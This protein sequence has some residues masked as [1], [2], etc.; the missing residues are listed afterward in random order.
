MQTISRLQLL[1]AVLTLG[2]LAGP[3]MIQ[4][5][6]SRERMTGTVVLSDTTDKHLVDMKNGAQPVDPYS[7]L[8]L[9]A[10]SA[11]VWDVSARQKLFALNS[12]ARLP[13]ASVTKIMTALVAA[14]LL[15]PETKITISA[16]DIRGEGDTG[17]NVGEV[18]QFEKL[19]QFTLVASSNDGASAI[20][21]TAGARLNLATSTSAALNK[22][23][24]V[25]KM[26][27]QA[28][29]MGLTETSFSN[30]TG[31]DLG[32]TESG[33]YGSAR[34]MAMLFDYVFRKY[35]A[36][37]TPTASS[38]LDVRSESDILHHVVNTNQDVEGI[39]GIIGSKTGYTDL[40]GGN[41]VVVVDIGI[42][43]PIV[44]AVLGSTRE[45]RFTDV[46]QLIRAT[47]RSIT[48]E[49]T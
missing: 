24:F 30:E 34:D 14:E 47:T 21:A 39:A 28:Q 46:K 9:R 35:P 2:F 33:A 44:I 38:V 32:S 49:K 42:D 15:P 1:L 31:L 41:L 11:Y 43:H 37:F 29:S 23:R 26:N 12:E 3:G 16:N 8:S 20:A 25:Q 27:E 45:D 5:L 48:E 7:T 18:W 40:A 13:L 4:A 10:K 17:L 36:I 22:K 6:Q 19:L